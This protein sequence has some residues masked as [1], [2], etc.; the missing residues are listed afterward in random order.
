MIWDSHKLPWTWDG[1][2]KSVPWSSLCFLVMNIVRLCHLDSLYSRLCHLDSLLSLFR[3]AY[4]LCRRSTK[5]HL[6]IMP[7]TKGAQGRRKPPTKFFLPTPMPRSTMKNMFVGGNADENPPSQW[8][9]RTL[10]L[11]GIWKHEVGHVE[12]RSIFCCKRRCT[13]RLFSFASFL[14]KQLNCKHSIVSHCSHACFRFPCRLWFVW[15]NRF[16]HPIAKD[17]Q[18]RLRLFI[19]STSRTCF[20]NDIVKKLNGAVSLKNNK[21]I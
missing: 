5:T 9:S 1:A 16:M 12:L 8:K 18:A 21:L 2:K 19:W 3:P 20:W 17:G 7:V 15:S 14:N 10:R 11:M 4:G 13:A 6:I